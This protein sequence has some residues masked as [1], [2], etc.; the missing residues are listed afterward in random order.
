MGLGDLTQEAVPRPEGAD[1]SPLLDPGNWEAQS[2]QKPEELS[3]YKSVLLFP[4]HSELGESESQIPC[5]LNKDSDHMC[6]TQAVR[7]KGGKTRGKKFLLAY[8]PDTAPPA[9]N[10]RRTRWFTAARVPTA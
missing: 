4:Q 5:L 6:L 8:T 10:E 2:G 9:C 7:V 3:Y 1:H